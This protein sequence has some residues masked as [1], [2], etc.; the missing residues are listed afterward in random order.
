MLEI[1]DNLYFQVDN[2]QM[3]VDLFFDNYF[4]FL[5]VETDI[6]K[7]RLNLINLEESEAIK[8]HIPAT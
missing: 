8:R 2:A 3:H 4:D 1:T 7:S 6:N 5:S